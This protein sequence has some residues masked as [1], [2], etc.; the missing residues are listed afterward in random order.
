MNSYISSY[1]NTSDKAELTTSFCH[2]E[3]FSKSGISIYISGHGW[4]KN[5]K[6]KKKK[7]KNAANCKALCISGKCNKP[8]SSN[9]LKIN[10][11]E[12]KPKNVVTSPGVEIYNKLNF[13]KHALAVF[14]KAKKQSMLFI[15]IKKCNKSH[16]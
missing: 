11:T 15:C 5:E 12:I 10:N 7:K 14:K 16:L 4:Q 3:R 6:K 8:N 2:I 13:K 9:I 1:M